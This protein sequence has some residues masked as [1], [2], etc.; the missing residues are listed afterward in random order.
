MPATASETSATTTVQPA[1][2]TAVPAVP[3]ARAIDSCISTPSRSCVRW[4]VT[5]NSA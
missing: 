5:R 1:N 3:T 2:T 4:R